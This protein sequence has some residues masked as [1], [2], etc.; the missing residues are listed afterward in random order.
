[1]PVT[2]PRLV[3]ENCVTHSMGVEPDRTGE[4]CR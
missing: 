3:S 1:M 2:D 4:M